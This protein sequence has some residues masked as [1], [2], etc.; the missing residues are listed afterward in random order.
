LKLR[1]FPAFTF[2]VGVMCAGLCAASHADNQ[3]QGPELF[4]KAVSLQEIHTQDGKPF[5]LQVQIQAKHIVTKPT[6]GTYDEVWMSPERWRREINMGGFDQVEVGG[7]NSKWVSRNADFRPR[8]AYLTAI[9]LESFFRPEVSPGEKIKSVRKRK[10]KGVELQCAQLEMAHGGRELCFDPSGALATEEHM[11]QR[12]EYSELG[13]FGEKIFP[14]SIRV[15]EA[16]NEV[17]NLRLED[18][19][20]PVQAVSFGHVASALQVAACERW[21]PAPDQKIQPQY[22][23]AARQAREQGV[24]VLYVAVTSDGRVS[25]LRVLE[26]AGESLNKSAA[27]AVRQWTYAPL[28]C[29]VGARLPSE[30]EVRVRYSLSEH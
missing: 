28:S 22:P 11:N 1:C 10:K 23:S 18:P 24:V 8:F 6:T 12:F 27:D 13:K 3:I 4:A 9:A 21:P 30:I 26:S 5:H 17:L 25:K 19:A 15:F 14:H 29:G 20:T 7:I 2:L 16:D